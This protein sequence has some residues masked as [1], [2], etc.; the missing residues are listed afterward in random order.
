MAAVPPPW[1]ASRSRARRSPKEWRCHERLDGGAWLTFLEDVVTG[2]YRVEPSTPADL[3]RCHEL[4]VQYADLPLGVVDAS[5]VALV[6]RLGERAVATLDHRHF[7]VVR[8]RHVAGLT[9]LP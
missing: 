5:V 4:Q 8:P 1:P 9:L 7:S 2:A 3:A 6:E